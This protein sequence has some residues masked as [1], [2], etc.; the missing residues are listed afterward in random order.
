MGVSYISTNLSKHVIV[1]IGISQVALRPKAVSKVIINSPKVHK[2]ISTH[3]YWWYATFLRKVHTSSNNICRQRKVHV[4]SK[5][6]KGAFDNASNISFSDA[7]IAVTQMQWHSL[8][9]ILLF[10]S[11]TIHFYIHSNITDWRISVCLWFSCNTFILYGDAQYWKNI[12]SLRI[13]D[14]NKTDHDSGQL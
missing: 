7:E 6:A 5:Y 1:A 3:F 13:M 12:G 11:A 8:N 14:S 2:S 9:V 10:Q 4:S